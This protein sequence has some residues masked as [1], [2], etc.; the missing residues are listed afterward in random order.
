M[1]RIW[2]S[3]GARGQIPNRDFV[4][5]Q[6]PLSFYAV[7]ATFRVL[8]TSL[9]S[10]RILGLAIFILIPSLIYGI[11]RCLMSKAMA[12]MA[13]IPGC[14]LGLPFF[15]FAPLAIWQGVAASK[16]GRASC[17]ERV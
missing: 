16:I 3:T 8:G 5:P 4:T 15:N 17:R 11:G 13:A 1:S 2:R 12:L 9:L 6:A 7:A 10:M 14:V